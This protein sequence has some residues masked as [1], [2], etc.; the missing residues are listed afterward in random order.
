MTV[1]PVAVRLASSHGM[2]RRVWHES[3]LGSRCVRPV[4][5]TPVL[6]TVASKPSG[7]VP[8]ARQLGHN[9]I[10]AD[11][12]DA[13]TRRLVGLGWQTSIGHSGDEGGMASPNDTAFPA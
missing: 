11:V 5:K 4:N 9:G 12:G 8:A 3:I 6:S 10:P 1:P 13:P 7:C 2:S